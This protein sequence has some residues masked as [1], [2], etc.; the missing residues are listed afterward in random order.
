MK[1]FIYTFAGS[2]FFFVALLSLVLLVT[3]LNGG[4]QTFDLITVARLAAGLPHA[5]QV[6][7]F[8]GLAVAFAVK[9][10]IVPFHTWLPDTYTEAPIGGS[11][12]I[13]G[14]MFALGGYGLL[15][16]GVF[17][18]PRG[19]ADMAPVL[20][21]LAT[22]G[23]VYGAVVTI[24]Q[25]D[26]KRLVAYSAIVS[27]AL[28]VLGEF[29]FSSQ[30]VAGGVMQMVN[31]SLTL[32][33]LFFL[34]GLV[35]DRTGSLRFADLGGLWT[36]APILAAIFLVVVLSAVGLPGLNG[37]VSEFLVLAG[38]FITHRWWAVVSTTVIITGAV[39]LLWAYQRTFWIKVSP[40]NRAVRDISWREI[41][42]VAPLLVGIVFLGVY[43]RVFFDRVTP[44]VGYL[45]G[46]VQHVAPNADVP[47]STQS[48]IKYTIPANQN[49]DARP[50]ASGVAAGSHP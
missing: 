2:A 1:F 18:V 13:S 36:P 46:H 3:P 31:E 23:V 17:L 19:A 6:L 7:I 49:V 26:L 47:A 42:M 10:P 43:P 30:G 35:R 37:F 39:Y 9:T 14:V 22:I 45:L 21:T 48:A 24:M 40:A 32:G 20:L 4:R 16:L 38:T 8:S 29:A 33:A 44:S 50:P 28:V 11:M 25:R 5:D 15:R 34:V 27:V 12:V 41:G